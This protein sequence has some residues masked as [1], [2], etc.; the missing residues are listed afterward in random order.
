MRSSD[1]EWKRLSAVFLHPPETTKEFFEPA[2]YFDLQTLA[3]ISLPRPPALESAPGYKRLSENTLGELGYRAL[4][5]QF[6]SDDEAKSAGSRWLADR[7]ILYERSRPAAYAIVAYQTAYL[8]AN[9]PV[10]FFCAMMTNDMGDTAKLSEYIGE[11]RAFGIE[12][13]PPDVNESYVYFAPAKDGKAPRRREARHEP[14][15]RAWNF[16]LKLHT[17]SW[18]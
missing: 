6:I 4:L 15:P 9:Y 7:Y 11:S 14:M 18:T 12:V 8:K 13:L 3:K 17:F 2:I 16:K 10:E 5:G 1:D